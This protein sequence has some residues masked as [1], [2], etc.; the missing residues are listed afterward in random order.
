[1]K[2]SDTIASN[3]FTDS[4]HY[5]ENIDGPPYQ[6]LGEGWKGE[7][8]MYPGKCSIPDED[9]EIVTDWDWKQSVVQRLDLPDWCK[10]WYEIESES[11]FDKQIELIRDKEKQLSRKQFQNSMHNELEKIVKI[12]PTSKESYDLKVLNHKL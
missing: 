4:G 2:K 10:E 7:M 11:Q 9:F 12:H 6:Y 1:M 3:R 8:S 5:H